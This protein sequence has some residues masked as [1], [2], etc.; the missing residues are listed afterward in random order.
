[1]SISLPGLNPT[2]PPPVDNLDA[3]WRHLTADLIFAA[4]GKSGTSEFLRILDKTRRPYNRDE[5]IRRCMTLCEVINNEHPK[6][7][8]RLQRAHACNDDPTFRLRYGHL[9]PRR[10]APIAFHSRRPG[11]T[12][13]QRE[14]E[15]DELVKACGI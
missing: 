10:P 3:Q 4:D 12:P 1:M 15:A 9:F 13:E 7:E 6:L 8:C 2:Q 5:A 11:P 14:A